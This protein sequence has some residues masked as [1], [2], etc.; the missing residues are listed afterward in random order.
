[1]KRVRKKEQK[2]RDDTARLLRSLAWKV[3]HG[4]RPLLSVSETF[5][6]QPRTLIYSVEVLLP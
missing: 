5:G 2:M 3:Q 4:K 6:G 1:M